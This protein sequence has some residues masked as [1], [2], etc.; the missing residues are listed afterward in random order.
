MHVT[1][2]SPQDAFSQMLATLLMFTF[3]QNLCGNLG[4]IVVLVRREG[5]WK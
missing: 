1:E 4:F 3:L 2:D 5:F